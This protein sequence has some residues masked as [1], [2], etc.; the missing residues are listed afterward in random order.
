MVI[1]DETRPVDGSRREAR[2]DYDKG[3]HGDEI[4]NRIYVGR[5]VG[6]RSDGPRSVAIGAA[7][8]NDSIRRDRSPEANAG[9]CAQAAASGQRAGSAA[10]AAATTSRSLS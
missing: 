2:P 3:C 10:T 4:S 6:G 7:R 8:G 1:A 9:Q 5:A